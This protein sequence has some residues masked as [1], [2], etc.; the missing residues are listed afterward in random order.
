MTLV[1]ASTMPHS[2]KI[3]SQRAKL[4]LWQSAIEEGGIALLE[5]QLRAYSSHTHHP[6]TPI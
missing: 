3:L 5:W 4:D 2:R 6:H 1:T